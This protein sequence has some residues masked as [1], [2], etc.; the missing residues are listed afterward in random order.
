ML[1]RP[2]TSTSEFETYY[3]LRWRVLREP[4]NQP[5]GSEKDDLEREAIHM[6]AWNDGGKMMGIGRLHRLGKNCGQL[7]YMAVDPAERSHG[8]GKAILLQLEAQALELGIEEIMLKSRQDAVSFYKKYGYNVLG[9]AHTLF[10]EIPHFEM[11]KRLTAVSG[12]F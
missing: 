5:R 2:P 1:V 12:E 6:A 3:E 8:V 11:R 9:P 10:G 4:W 7:R